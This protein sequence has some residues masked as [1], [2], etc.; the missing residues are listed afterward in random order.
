[1]VLWG[2]KKSRKFA[3]LEHTISSFTI[4]LWML[5]YKIY[6]KCNQVM[7]WLQ[8]FYW[9][10]R[11]RPII[12]P[13]QT[14]QSLLFHF[15]NTCIQSILYSGNTS[16]K[17]VYIPFKINYPKLYCFWMCIIWF[18]KEICLFFW[19]ELIWVLALPWGSLHNLVL[20]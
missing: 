15:K 16:N 3:A 13:A 2:K 10:V 19:L 9:Q 1:M 6:S 14:W 4:C 20:R 11:Q 8:P 7:L 18:P 5:Q 12:K 17:L